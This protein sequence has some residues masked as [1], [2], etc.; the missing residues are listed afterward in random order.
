MVNS[1]QDEKMSVKQKLEVA[2]QKV[3]SN[4]K[5]LSQREDTNGATEEEGK[6]EDFLKLEVSLRTFPQL[7]FY[8][9]YLLIIMLGKLE[10]IQGEPCCNSKAMHADRIFIEMFQNHDFKE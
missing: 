10:K 5:D 7:I 9:I 6:K 3:Y 1:P 8:I 4:I 2:E